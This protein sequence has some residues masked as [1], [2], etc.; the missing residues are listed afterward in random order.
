MVGDNDLLIE[1]VKMLREKTEIGDTI[2]FSINR[3][4]REISDLVSGVVTE[5]YPNIFRL[6][7]KKTYRWVDYALGQIR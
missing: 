7:D 4:D 1:E 6:D 5:K 2:I 3:L